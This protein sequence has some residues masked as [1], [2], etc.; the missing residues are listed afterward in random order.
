MTDAEK[1]QAVEAALDGSCAECAQLVFTHGPSCD[2][3]EC[4]GCK[5]LYA[6]CVCPATEEEQ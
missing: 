4:P 5:T 3:W 6:A 1:L 2:I